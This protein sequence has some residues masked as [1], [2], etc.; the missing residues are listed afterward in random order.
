MYQDRNG[1]MCQATHRL[2]MAKIHHDADGAKN[3]TSWHPAMAGAGRVK[4][5]TPNGKHRCSLALRW[6]RSERVNNG[7]TN[8]RRANTLIRRYW[9]REGEP[10]KLMLAKTKGIAIS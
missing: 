9:I 4:Y 2:E 3:Q 1:E 8:Q 7:T 6:A 5:H 10:A